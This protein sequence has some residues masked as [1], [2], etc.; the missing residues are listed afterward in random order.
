MRIALGFAAARMA[1]GAPF[2]LATAAS[3]APSV[4]V[5]VCIGGG[6]LLRYTDHSTCSGGKH[7]GEPISQ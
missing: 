1:V 6:G 4:T 2:A 7:D 3:A 5:H